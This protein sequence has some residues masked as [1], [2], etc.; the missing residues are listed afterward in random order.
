MS[1]VS[2]TRQR[3]R[4]AAA[5]LVT[6]GK[7]PHEVTVD[8]IYAVIQQG[9]RT[10][11]NDELK[12]W[13]DERT[14]VDAL[15]ADL[16]AAVADAMRALWVAAVEQGETV[17]AEQRGTLETALAEAEQRRDAASQARDEAL[18]AT[19]ALT[20]QN[21]GLRQ[22]VVMVQARAE[23]ETTAKDQA[24]QEGQ[25]LQQKLIALQAETAEQVERIRQAQTVQAEEF[26]TAIANRDAAFQAEREKAN[27]RL[28][29][30]QGRML[31]EID[32]AREGQR[33]AEGHLAKTQG[34]MEQQQSSLAELRLGAGRHRSELAERDT[35][36]EVLSAAVEERDRTAIELAAARG[37]LAGLDRAMQSLDV[38]ATT[39]ETR[40]AALLA[41]R[42]ST[43]P[44]RSKRS[45]QERK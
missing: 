12:Q 29:S 19:A 5:Q 32:A 40:I 3:T 44:L 27:E 22:Q 41:E 28:E 14:K 15:G 26:Q 23:S 30:A 1:R 33:R 35:R 18:A 39:A 4:E 16:P 20:E 11:I 36:L 45:K 13:K 24:L 25:A 34:R 43:A 2:D 10:T 42:A 38:R 37:Q 9:S 7:R 6:G 21:D 31:Q 8:Q 17:F